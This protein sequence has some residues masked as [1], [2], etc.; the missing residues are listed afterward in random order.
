MTLVSI[1][2]GLG[3]THVLGA[4]GASVHRLKGRGDPIRFDPVYLLWIAFV[5][6][7]LLSFWWWEF[8]LRDLDIKWTFGVYL[9]LISYA[10]LL[11]LMAVILVPKGMEGVTDTYE[12]FMSGRRWFFAVV[13][14]ANVVDV[15]D[16]FLKGT[17]WALR[18]DYIVQIAVFM[19]V[20]VIGINSAR[21]GVQ[22]TL[23]LV[24]FAYQTIYTWISID[25]LGGW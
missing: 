21:R 2:V 5:L 3:L 19:T 9:F 6:I 4:L 8:K 13:L 7:W 17:G 23:A 11:Y 12:Y 24:M 25:I 16:S 20:P 22:F 10:T 1:V 18:P 15:G 14:L